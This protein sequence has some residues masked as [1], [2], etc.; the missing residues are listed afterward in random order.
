MFDKD[1]RNIFKDKTERAVSNT[2]VDS[3]GGVVAAAIICQHPLAL[4]DPPKITGHPDLV[5]GKA[6]TDSSREVNDIVD[7]PVVLRA[8]PRNSNGY[9]IPE[10]RRTR[11]ALL[12]PVRMSKQ[13]APNASKQLAA[14]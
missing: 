2:S 13:V 8:W 4:L 3:F 11:L 12:P 5:I 9:R 6:R 7:Q 10:M 1:G 14:V